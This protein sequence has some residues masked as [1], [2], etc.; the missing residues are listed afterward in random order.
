MDF[1]E[2]D[3][4]QFN[5]TVEEESWDSI[6]ENAAKVGTVVLVV[7]VI[8]G[9]FWTFNRFWHRHMMQPPVL[10]NEEDE[11]VDMLEEPSLVEVEA[12]VEVIKTRLSNDPISVADTVHEWLAEDQEVNLE[13]R[14]PPGA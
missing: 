9:M 13:V 6:M 7:L 14:P 3:K 8:L 5:K 4:T 10:D 2:F 1:V 11:E 12:M